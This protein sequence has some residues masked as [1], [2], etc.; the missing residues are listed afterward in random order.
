M[1]TPAAR[2]RAARR[3]SLKCAWCG[4]AIV[5][6]HSQVMYCPGKDCRRFA[7]EDRQRRRRQGLSSSA[8]SSVTRRRPRYPGRG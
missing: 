3:R 2:S 5:T 1:T 4:T 7:H 6:Y 8:S